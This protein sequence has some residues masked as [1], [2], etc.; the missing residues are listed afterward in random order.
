MES[1]KIKQVM[2]RYLQEMLDLY[3]RDADDNSGITAYCRLLKDFLYSALEFLTG[4]FTRENVKIEILEIP[5]ELQIPMPCMRIWDGKTRVYGYIDVLGP[6]TTKKE[7][8]AYP[9][10]DLYKRV[11]P[12]LLLTNFF[13]FIYYRED[14]KVCT[15]RPLTFSQ[16]GEITGKLKALQPKIFLKALQHFMGYS[17]KKSKVPSFI[18]L[19]KRLALKTF[20]LKEYVLTPLMGH[21]LDTR[22]KC[23]LVRLYRAYC[24]FFDLELSAK[25]F[26]AFLAHA[27]VDG[28]IRAAVFHNTRNSNP[29]S[30][31][32]PGRVF[33]FAKSNRMTERRLA[34]FKYLSPAPGDD[35]L[36]GSVQWV[37]DDLGGLL[38]NYDFQKM[39]YLCKNNGLIDGALLQWEVYFFIPYYDTAEEIE[40][41]KEL[42]I[43]AGIFSGEKG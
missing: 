35:E 14:Q 30:P 43:K 2:N 41:V 38:G 25:E 6:G 7:I 26:S 23:E 4:N 17:D 36:P 20:Y 11:F 1:Q 5:G 22:A 40:R 3:H 29:G 33:E 34:L 10:L 37:L 42:L 15:A 18:D 16:I 13:E 8:D 24:Y 21:W 28:F 19:Q 32:S 31:F 39:G 12:N 9:W 27:I